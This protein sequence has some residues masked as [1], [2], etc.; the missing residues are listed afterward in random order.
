MEKLKILFEEVVE[1]LKKENPDYVPTFE[2][3]VLCL[4]V[5]DKMTKRLFEGLVKETMSNAYVQSPSNSSP[6]NGTPR[7]PRSELR[8]S[9]ARTTLLLTAP[10]SALLPLTGSGGTLTLIP[11][12]LANRDANH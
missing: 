12:F 2:D 4:D 9:G 5:K 7:S 1:K 6:P 8:D 10:L 3:F 11:A